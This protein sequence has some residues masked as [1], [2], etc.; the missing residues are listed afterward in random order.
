MEANLPESPGSS[1][2][3]HM[4]RFL[5]PQQIA[6]ID[7]ALAA[8]GD[9]GELKLVVERGR[10]RFLV[11]QKSFDAL[12]WQPGWILKELGSSDQD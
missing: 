4:P 9:Y 11:A 12:K 2:N 7:E 8:L 5:R 6:M 1:A 10:L 3:G